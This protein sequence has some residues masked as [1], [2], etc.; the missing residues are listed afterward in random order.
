M[1][2]YNRRC[3]RIRWKLQT[4]LN[5]QLSSKWRE[6]RGIEIVSFGVNSVKA[7]EE[8]E[9]TIKEMQRRAAYRDPTRAAGSARARA[10]RGDEVCGSECERRSGDGV[11]GY[12]YGR[13]GRRRQLAESVRNGSAAGPAAGAGG[14]RVDV[15]VRTDRQ[16][17]KIL[18]GLRAETRAEQ[19]EMRLRYGQYRKILF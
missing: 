19:L 12:E 17:R 1:V 15:L 7:D 8:D 9:K 4:A 16:H 2:C 6:L 5:E 11:H 10:G 14:G 18:H 3:P 13:S